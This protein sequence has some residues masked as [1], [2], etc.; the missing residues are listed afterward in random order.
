[1][2]L[3]LT[4]PPEIASARA[5]YGTE[6]YETIEIQTRVR[7]QF[8]QVGDVVRT[9]HGDDKWVEIVASSTIE[10][11]GDSIWTVVEPYILRDGSPSLLRLWEPIGEKE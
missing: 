5:A 2:T 1:M 3:Y 4:V 11:V 7:K 9:R 6:R 8:S 10:E